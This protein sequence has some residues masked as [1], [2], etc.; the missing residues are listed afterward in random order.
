MTVIDGP[1]TPAFVQLFQYVAK[2]LTFL[3][4]CAKRYGD[5]FEANLGTST[6]FLS[7]PKAIQDLFSANP[8]HFK[9]GHEL[10][11]LRP[12]MGDNSLLVI[13]GDRHQ[14]HRKL[15]MPP[16]HGER[17]QAYGKLI[18]D[19]TEAAASKW[20][21][22]KP[23][24]MRGTTKT[25][26]LQVILQAIFGL[27]Q[28]E[29]YEQIQK[30]AA[31]LMA[32]WAS[33][34]ISAALFFKWLRMDIGPWSPWGNFVR[35]RQQF[36]ELLF[37]EISDRRSSLD[38]NR[39]DILTMLLLAQD[40]EGE[41][42][43]DEE[44]HDE[45][46]TLLVGGHETTASALAW[47]FY[48]IHRQAE[49]REKLLQELA[50]LPEGAEELEPMAIMQLPY[51]N[52]VCCETLRI[53]PIIPFTVGRLIAS[54]ITI[55]GR[56][57]GVGKSLVAN[58]YLVHRREDLYPEA[59]KFKPERFLERQFSASEFVPFG[60]GNRRC[61]GAAF[62]MFEMKLVLATI[63]RRYNLALAEKGEVKPVHRSTLSGPGGGVK[64]VMLERRQSDRAASAA[65]VSAV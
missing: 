30:R 56:E 46:L 18:C 37:A 6:V 17:M 27:C 39:T 42:L 50:A 7:D 48:W 45:L 12:L 29:R 61:I 28:G 16:L 5:T 53:Y 51:L 3:E 64:M 38:P 63:L 57:Y 10:D 60:G 36:D 34:P 58:I 4:D 2:P 20:I 41:C 26:S 8:K 19:L 11:V 43:S 24:V 21:P 1:K 22:G 9:V 31:A 49:I 47:A 15:L 52:A 23:F 59:Q 54:P 25:I 35:L 40:A 62:A 44:L 13:D 33:G 65:A 55:G 14:R 32:S